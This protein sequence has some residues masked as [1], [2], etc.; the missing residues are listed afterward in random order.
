MTRGLMTNPM[1]PVIRDEDGVPRF[2]ENALVA[3]LFR[4]GPLKMSQIVDLP[5]SEDDFEQFLQ[6]IGYTVSG[7]Q[8]Y[9]IREESKDAAE[10][11]ALHTS[12]VKPI[13]VKI[14]KGET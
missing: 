7:Y 2:K 5:F 10:L 12:E 9:N 13:S 14:T 6:L 11:A 4:H 8:D 1:Q 3:Y